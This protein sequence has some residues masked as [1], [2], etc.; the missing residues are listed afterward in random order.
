[1]ADAIEKNTYAVSVCVH[2]FMP[3]SDALIC[4]S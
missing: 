1:M 4:E 3:T 2:E